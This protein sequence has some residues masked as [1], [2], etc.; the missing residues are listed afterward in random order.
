MSFEISSGLATAQHRPTPP[1]HDDDARPRLVSTLTPNITLLPSRRW[2][3]DLVDIARRL[4]LTTFIMLF[5]VA[6]TALVFASGVAVVTTSSTASAT[7]TSTR[8][9]AASAWVRTGRSF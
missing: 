5:D 9:S 3:Y 7:R 6:G 4:L 8:G 1:N 2:A